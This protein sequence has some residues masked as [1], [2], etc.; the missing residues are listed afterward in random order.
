MMSGGSF[1]LAVV[2]CWINLAI[3]GSTRS[4]VY[5]SEYK[6]GRGDDG[7]KKEGDQMQPW[8]ESGMCK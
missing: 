4:M 2:G 8:S 3:L 5:E 7:G 1:Q 6:K